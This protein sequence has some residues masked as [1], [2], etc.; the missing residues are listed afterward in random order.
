[1]P[2]GIGQPLAPPP[3]DIAEVLATSSPLD[4][5]TPFDAS[6]DVAFAGFDKWT[7]PEARKANANRIT[8]TQSARVTVYNYLGDDRE[9]GIED[10]EQVLASGLPSDKRLHLRCPRCIALPNG[11]L[12]TTSGP[13]SCPGKAQAKFMVCPICA[14]RG[15][16]KRVYEAD[17][18]ALTPAEDMAEDP[19]YEAYA[20]PDVA[21]RREVLQGRLELHMASFH[22]SDAQALYGIRRE[23]SGNGWRIVRGRD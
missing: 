14:S 12:H 3:S 6:T 19:N 4:S 5:T 15:F 1:M 21:S 11:G 7:S 22:A 23:T 10:L 9:I 13:N 2:R 8:H 18:A 17:E 20:L 16:N